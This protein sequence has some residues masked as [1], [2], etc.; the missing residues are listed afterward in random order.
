MKSLTVCDVEKFEFDD[1]VSFPDTLGSIAPTGK[2]LAIAGD[3]L[4]SYTCTYNVL[5]S[6]DILAKDMTSGNFIPTEEYK[7]SNTFSAYYDQTKK[8]LYLLTPSTISKGFIKSLTDAYLN[9]IGNL[10]K[11]DFDFAKIASFEDGARGIYFNVD[12]DTDVD[13]KHFFGSGVQDNAE[14]IEALD[15]NNATYLMAKLD[16]NNKQ[17]TIGFSK[18]GTLVIYSKPDTGEEEKDYLELA[19]N[20]LLA[21]NQQ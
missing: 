9:K 20:T 6:E 7:K 19:L 13:S 12:D 21:I 10:T 5:I 2:T 14:V 15:K 1:S 11:H 8:I 18:K 4:Q 16:V 3:I 17:R